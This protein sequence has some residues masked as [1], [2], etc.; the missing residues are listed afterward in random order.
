MRVTKRELLDRAVIYFCQGKIEYNKFSYEVYV[1][2]SIVPSRWK[3][4][5]W[6]ICTN[7]KHCEKILFFKLQ[8]LLIF[9]G[10]SVCCGVFY[11]DI[12]MRDRELCYATRFS[13][14][15]SWV[16]LN[17]TFAIFVLSPFWEICKDNRK[18]ICTFLRNG[19]H[20]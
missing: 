1:L 14:C 11:E 3:E 13:Y 19:M 5:P 18:R 4:T 7:L 15:R 12:S 8:I 20:E 16:F 17:F 10:V 6:R 2:C 9:I